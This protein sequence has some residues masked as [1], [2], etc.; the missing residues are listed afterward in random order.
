MITASK[1]GMADLVNGLLT[2]GANMETID[3]NGL[4]GLT[5]AIKGGYSDVVE[6]F[7]EHDIQGYDRELCLRESNKHKLNEKLRDAVKSG[8]NG[9]VKRLTKLGADV[10]CNSYLQW[11]PLII[12]VY[13]GHTKTLKILLD[14]GADPDL[15][16]KQVVLLK[17]QALKT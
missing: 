13:H 5:L 15:R 7:F 9:A 3:E 8:E 12:A 17:S 16:D 6:T 4:I 11:S 1:R 14:F 10:N 2:A